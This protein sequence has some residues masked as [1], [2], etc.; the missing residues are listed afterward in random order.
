MEKLEIYIHIPFCVKKCDYCDFLSMC[1]DNSTKREYVSA[2]INEIKLSKDRMKGYLVDTVFIGGGTPSILEGKYISDIM[3]TL[4]E[5]C[6]IDKNAEI[7]IECNPGTVDSYK[8]EQYK[9][10][11]INRISLG[12]QS[13][14]DEELAAIGR[15]HNYSKFEE[16]F[17][18]ARE[19]G[20]TN[21][22]VDIMSALP[23]QTLESYQNTIKKVL[24]LN[25]EHIS[26]YS[27]IVEEETPLHDKV[28]QAEEAG[29]H[30]LPEE[31]VEREMYYDT[32]KMLHA[33]GY[34]RYEI[35]NYCKK[36]YM[37]RHNVGYWKR[38]EYLGFGLGAASLYKDTRYSNMEDLYQYISVMSES[39][40]DSDSSFWGDEIYEDNV[41]DIQEDGLTIVQG[42]IQQLSVKDRIEEFMFLGLRMMEGISMKTFEEMF[43]RKYENVY[44][45]VS[46]KLVEQGLLEQN[47]DNIRLTKRGIDI[48]NYVMSEFLL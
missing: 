44:G 31:D 37:C 17:Y 45:T 19:A 11:G 34:E 47:G 33:A 30:I 1:A 18:L 40:S 3:E 12:L 14:N 26:A 42:K 43:G 9:K 29:I 23:G 20:F 21:I 5:C 13:A 48:S 28:E 41:W 2:L 6:R 8:L 10:V 4:R 24:S 22:N 36:G 27:L 16:S 25:P 46:D 7:T 38:T 35:S 32:E 39:G 15:I